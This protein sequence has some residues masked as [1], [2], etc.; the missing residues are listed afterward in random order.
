MPRHQST[1]GDDGAIKHLNL[2]LLR[3]LGLLGLNK[4]ASGPGVMPSKLTNIGNEKK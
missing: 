2:G 1:H 3:L 4:G